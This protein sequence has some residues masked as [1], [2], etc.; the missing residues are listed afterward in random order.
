MNSPV[1]QYEGPETTEFWAKAAYIL[2]LVSLIFGITGL[3]A[4]V[5]A[6]VNRNDS[7]AWLQTHYQ[8]QIRT[9]WIGMLYVLIGLLL[10]IVLVGYLVLLLAVVW[11]V[12]RCIKGLKYLGRRQAYPDPTGWWF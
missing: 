10:M 9:F 12:V 11:L 8:F 5:I 7:P 4:L 2:Y 1:M 6:Y 3:V